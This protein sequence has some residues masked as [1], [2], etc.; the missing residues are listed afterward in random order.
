MYGQGHFSYIEEKYSYFYLF[1]HNTSFN[2]EMMIYFYQ[3]IYTCI[4][5]EVLPITFTHSWL[6]MFVFSSLF[7]RLSNGSIDPDSEVNRVIELQETVEKQNAELTNTRTK[8]L[9]L[10]NRFSEIEE[11]YTT[12]QKDLI[13]SQ[14]QLV[15]L[16]RDLREVG[17]WRL[18]LFCKIAKILLSILTLV[19]LNLDIPCLWKLFGFR[20][21]GIFRNQLI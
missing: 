13:K 7:Q 5:N 16:Q 15:K 4:K 2:V 20:S 14:E 3:K 9:E 17:G 10:N 21:D 11:S 19:L 1:L 8:M 12:S 18:D 6:I